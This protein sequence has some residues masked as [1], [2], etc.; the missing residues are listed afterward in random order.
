MI[1]VNDPVENAVLQTQIQA[2]LDRWLQPCYTKP[3]EHVQASA[4][5]L[6]EIRLW[7]MVNNRHIVEEAIRLTKAIPGV[8][9][10]SN[11]VIV[12]YAGGS[13]SLLEVDSFLDGLK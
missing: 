2:A 9:C 10:V 5:N 13:I 3:Y 7:G 8:R 4:N 6:G 11:F 1:A 12:T